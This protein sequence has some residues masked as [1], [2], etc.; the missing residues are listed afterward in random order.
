MKKR[1][2]TMSLGFA[3]LSACP[4]SARDYL[5]C[6]ELVNQRNLLLS[7]AGLAEIITRSLDI[8][9]SCPEKKFEYTQ[10]RSGW[11]SEDG[12]I[13][14]SSG[15]IAVDREKLDSCIDNAI[16]NYESEH[17]PA[18]VLKK[19]VVLMNDSEFKSKYDKLIIG[20]PQLKI[21]SSK[22]AEFIA[23]ANE[24]DDEMRANQC[25]YK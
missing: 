2:V 1:F 21:F 16:A 8:T 10:K 9:R 17:N 22:A 23:S 25:P 6:N 19:G 11:F 5:K 24:I 20:K 3:L 13:F 15:I 12:S 4:L 18:L 7:K 14:S